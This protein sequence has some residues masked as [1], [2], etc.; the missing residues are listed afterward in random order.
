MNN[1]NKQKIKEIKSLIKE[2]NI[3]FVDCSNNLN[4][5]FEH[6]DNKDNV[7]LVGFI[8]GKK[9]DKKFKNYFSMY[10]KYIDISHD[11]S[12]LNHAIF[13]YKT[14]TKIIKNFNLFTKQSLDKFINNIKDC[15]ICM[16][17]DCE[18]FVTCINCSYKICKS[19]CDKLDECPI[20][21]KNYL[22]EYIKKV[23]NE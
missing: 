6:Y 16:N 5:L 1:P 18:K 13:S 9:F 7:I 11:D 19:C 10:L 21:R 8:H 15:P 23:L 14:T 2:Y 22:N 12:L 4:L 3:P 17:D 20:C